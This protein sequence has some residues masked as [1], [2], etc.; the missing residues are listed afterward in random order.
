MTSEVE[1]FK[2]LARLILWIA[3]PFKPHT[4]NV[5]VLSK[6]TDHI[7]HIN[8]TPYNKLFHFASKFGGEAIQIH[9]S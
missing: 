6:F 3:I 4:K 9:M 5:Y 7:A 8:L 1:K 2:G